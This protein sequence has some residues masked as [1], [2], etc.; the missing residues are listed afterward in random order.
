MKRLIGLLGLTV[1]WLGVGCDGA[2]S[3]T[4]TSTTG[5]SGGN[6][7]SSSTGMGATGGNTSSSSTVGS[8]TGGMASGGS[9]AGGMSTGG[10][11]TGGSSTG[12]TNTGG[13]GTGT[14]GTG[15]G[16]ST[17]GGGGQGSTGTTTGTGGMGGSGQGGSGTGGMPE[18]DVPHPCNPGSFWDG[19]QCTINFRTL[20]IGAEHVHALES[21]G[22]IS[23]WGLLSSEKNVAPLVAPLIHANVSTPT[24]AGTGWKS[25]HAG[26]GLGGLGFGCAI[27]D[28]DALL[29]WGNDVANGAFVSS[30]QEI[31]P[32]S[33]WRSIDLGRQYGCGIHL[34]GSLWCWGLG[35]DKVLGVS[36]VNVAM[37]PIQ[38]GNQT[39]WAM[40]STGM[41]HVCALKTDGDVYCWGNPM[42]GAAST[43]GG[44]AVPMLVA[45]GYM[46]VD[47]GTEVTCGIKA[48]GTLWCWGDN[49]RW[50]LGIGSS[51]PK[52]SSTPLQVG[53]HI[54][55]RRVEVGD[56]A[57]CGIRQEGSLY[58]WGGLNYYYQLAAE[59]F[60][61]VPPP[62]VT[63]MAPVLVGEPNSYSEVAL[64]TGTIYF[65]SACARR[66][67]GEVDC[68]GDNSQ[69]QLGMGSFGNKDLPTAVGSGPWKAGDGTCAIKQDGTLWCW[70]LSYIKDPQI[71]P[72]QSGT[73]TDWKD[74]TTSGSGSQCAIKND[75]TLWCWGTSDS[76]ALGLGVG[77]KDVP[78]PM[79]VGT[80][81][82]TKVVTGS[83]SRCGI[84][85][86]GAM[87]CWGSNV[88]G[89]LGDGTQDT[90]FSPTPILSAKTWIDV[91]LSDATCGVTTQGEL[92][93][94]GDGFT[95]TP[96][97]FGADTNWKS[98]EVGRYFQNQFC[99]IRTT[100]ALTC[101]GQAPFG[102]GTNI[103]S[104]TPVTIGVDT[105]WAQVSM[106]G[107]TICGTRTDNRL[108]CWG[109]D[110]GA[111]AYGK[112][113][114]NLSPVQMFNSDFAWV[115]ASAFSLMALKTDGSL[116][117]WGTGY[118]GI[119]A[120]GDAWATVP[121]PV[122]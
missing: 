79:Q 12:G 36:G 46:F 49:D 81:T 47:A 114:T 2:E 80:A 23:Y 29:C 94:W 1:V 107:Q 18:P 86:N 19:T 22:S 41:N 59:Y 87:F 122:Q 21:N 44:S 88:K 77:V 13:T 52:L 8:S 26:G 4:A 60:A 3:T 33:L 104:A 98:I 9:G 20:E 121:T 105:D 35:T 65:G 58:C 27:R 39:D 109:V 17:T 76:G 85:T 116:V 118:G 50:Q 42:S 84:Q 106:K 10:T 37:D 45:T 74:V 108:F 43:A 5:G 32:G 51:N 34:D 53:T 7:T 91:S 110:R 38:V 78:L 75:N 113:V 83:S 120:H 115:S 96:T 61:T 54:D 57:V 71:S 64:S 55:W 67:T 100:G 93:C 25:V 89:V 28:D 82:W 99:G 68:W 90:R 31:A 111:G 6:A 62:A 112:V 95:P 24:G 30:P 92:Y 70:A 69:G 117:T 15:N 73:A 102:D 103:S 66:K 11:S 119:L 16:G 72:K 48:D 40:V 97:Q 63:S 56:S 14:G 101:W